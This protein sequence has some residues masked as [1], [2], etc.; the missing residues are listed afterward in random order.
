M[1][2]GCPTTESVVGLMTQPYSHHPH[3]PKGRVAHACLY[4]GADLCDK[5]TDVY[6][7]PHGQLI[8]V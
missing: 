8:E 7:Q 2:A 3:S 5:W 1:V 6:G 4:A